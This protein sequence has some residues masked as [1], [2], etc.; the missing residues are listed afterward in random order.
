M[1]TPKHLRSGPVEAVMS[2]LLADYRS[3]LSLAARLLAGR[4]GAVEL[5]DD[6]RSGFGGL[7]SVD[8][9]ELLLADEIERVMREQAIPT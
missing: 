6:L 8:T 3:A 5:V 2:D 4:D 7:M 1:H 9:Y